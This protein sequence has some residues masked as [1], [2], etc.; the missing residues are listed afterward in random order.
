MSRF[1]ADS[2]LERISGAVDESKGR[3]IRAA[4]SVACGLIFY[5]LLNSMSLKA[6]ARGHATDAGIDIGV[7]LTV[8]LFAMVRAVFYIFY[9]ARRVRR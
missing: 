1:T 4:A 3:F 9:I 2:L 8:L 6:L 5:G 7:G